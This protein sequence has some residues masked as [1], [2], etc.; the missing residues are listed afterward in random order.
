MAEQSSPTGYWAH[1]HEG[2]G[3]DE[4]AYTLPVVGFEDDR[5]IFTIK[6]YAMVCHEDGYL[7]RADQA[8]FVGRFFA[9]LTYPE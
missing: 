2:E 9:V 8:T 3:A 5:D 7:V 1:Y 4:V 6:R